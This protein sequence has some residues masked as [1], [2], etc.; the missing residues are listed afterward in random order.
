M[1]LVTKDLLSNFLFIFLPLFLIH[2]F[3]L[4]KYVNR[5][6]ELKDW[7]IIF[8]PIASIILCML[9]PIEIDE[10]FILDLRRIPFILG[11][12]MVGIN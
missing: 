10:H 7:M 12:L 11:A 8:F 4:S 5:F 1:S 9:F 3:Y 6:G 2:I